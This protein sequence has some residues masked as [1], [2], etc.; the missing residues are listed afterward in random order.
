MLDVLSTKKC[1]H[2]PFGFQMTI[3]DI[4]CAVC[5]HA[6][7]TVDTFWV[8]SGMMD[9]SGNQKTVGEKGERTQKV[10]RVVGPFLFG[11][12]EKFLL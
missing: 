8:K 1:Q 10:L 4:S 6:Y 7:S 3:Y 2:Q 9:Q 11:K 12:I 5:L